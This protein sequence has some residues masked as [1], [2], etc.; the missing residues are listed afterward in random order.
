MT[1]EILNSMFSSDLN[2]TVI[3]DP[4]QIRFLVAQS[5]ADQINEQR[6]S[7][8]PPKQAV[9]LT[10]AIADIIIETSAQG[11]SLMEVH[12]IDPYWV[13]LQ[14][15]AAGI[16]FIDV[17]EQGYLWPPIEVNFPKGSSDAMWRLCACAPT[18]DLTTA[19]IVL[20]FEDRCAA[21]LR[22][23]QGPVQSNHN[24]T[25]AEFIRRLVKEAR[26]GGHLPSV[27][28]N[29]VATSPNVGMPDGS[30]RFITLLG[31]GDPQAFSA[32]D[33]ASDQVYTPP[34]AKQPA[35]PPAR[36]SPNKTPAPTPSRGGGPSTLGP[37]LQLLIDQFTPPPSGTNGPQ[38]PV[39]GAPIGPPV[40]SAPLPVT[41]GEPN[42]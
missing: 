24:E 40:P 38:G 26:F 39:P 31:I 27:A 8:S 21:E 11:A 2:A 33:L 5:M 32:A 28:Y 4:A 35:A 37:D 29:G 1:N 14:R 17:D 36:K 23:F 16:C 10:D 13:L 22:E 42:T 25:R 15:D 18:T 41:S 12:I 7:F 9:D 30:I 20:T 3:S 6:M 19:N 34:S